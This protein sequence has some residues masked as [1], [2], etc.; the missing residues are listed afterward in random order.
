MLLS[1]SFVILFFILKEHLSMYPFVPALLFGT[2]VLLLVAAML[3]VLSALPP[4]PVKIY[5]KLDLVDALMNLYQ[6]EYRRAVSSAVCLFL[7]LAQLCLCAGDFRL[8]VHETL[9]CFLNSRRRLHFKIFPPDTPKPRQGWFHITTTCGN[10]LRTECA[11]AALDS[12]QRWRHWDA[13]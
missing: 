10:C 3:S 6:R 8:G 1:A 2:A 11:Y 7:G 13:M 5:G 9:A 12:A 4:R